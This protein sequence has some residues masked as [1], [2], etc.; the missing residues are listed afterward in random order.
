MRN[1][2]ICLVALGALSACKPGPLI[3][4]PTPKPMKSAVQSRPSWA[5]SM[6]P[7]CFATGAPV[8]DR[9]M[10]DP[11]ARHCSNDDARVCFWVDSVNGRVWFRP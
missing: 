3:D 8:P 4:P 5:A 9:C 6:E 1:L 11:A 10:E 7:E 2:V